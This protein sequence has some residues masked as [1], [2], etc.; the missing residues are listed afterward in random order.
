MR[1]AAAGLVA[2]LLSAGAAGAHAA[3][4]QPTASVSASSHEPGAETALTVVM[5]YEMQC[6]SPG[7]GPVLLTLPHGMSVPPSLGPSSVLVNGAPAVSV[8]VHGSLLTVGIPQR[9]GG[10]ICDVIGPGKLTVV[11]PKTTGLRNPKTKGTYPFHVV[12][13]P[14]DARPTIRISS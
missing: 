4:P 10:I 6:G 3:L 14:L 7:A 11:I 8:K 13:G 1:I 2:C 9:T 12:I 5:S